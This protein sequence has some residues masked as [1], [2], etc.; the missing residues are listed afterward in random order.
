MDEE[1]ISFPQPPEDPPWGDYPWSS[2]DLNNDTPRNIF[3]MFRSFEWSNRLEIDE[4]KGFVRSLETGEYLLRK[5]RGF[6]ELSFF[7]LRPPHPGMVA[8][9][10]IRRSWHITFLLVKE[11]LNPLDFIEHWGNGYRLLVRAYRTFKSVFNDVDTI[12]ISDEYKRDIQRR[13]NYLLLKPQKFYEVRSEIERIN[14]TA[15]SSKESLLRYLV[16]N[17]K[18]DFLNE[19]VRGKTNFN[20]GDFEFQVKRFNLATKT[21]R[22][23]FFD[24]LNDLDLEMLS[25]LFEKMLKKGVFSEEY[26]TKLDDYFI[27]ESLVEIVRRGRGILEL[28][29]GGI[30][31][32]PAKRIIRKAI[33]KNQTVKQLEGVWQKF[34]EKYLLYLFFSYKKIWELYRQLPLL[35][36]P[37]SIW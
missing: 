10:L 26:I 2:D 16:N 4:D 21:T 6:F 1:S 8:D 22:E 31:T 36:L 9:E 20:Q 32:I 15:E 27:K 23:D 12:R 7:M 25:Q 17:L 30:D 33:G 11:N 14:Q 19:T 35:K 29:S 18:H 13:E 34:F 37:K 3:Q 28:R 5:R 24:Y